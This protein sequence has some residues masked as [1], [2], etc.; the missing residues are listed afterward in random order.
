MTEVPRIEA[1]Q[2]KRGIINCV[3]DCTAI[4]SHRNLEPSIN[5]GKWCAAKVLQEQKV[6]EKKG[7]SNL[8]SLPAI[9]SA[10]W[11]KNFHCKTFQRYL[12]MAT[13]TFTH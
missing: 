4:G 7:K 8:A 2:K 1:E 5:D 11:R 6:Q 9:P 13:C 3:R 12:T 10:G